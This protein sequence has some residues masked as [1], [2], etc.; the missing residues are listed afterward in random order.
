MI[1][2]APCTGPALAER[3]LPLPPRPA[4][5]GTHLLADLE[6]ASRLDEPA[7]V[8]ATLRA[9]ADAA[10][11]TLL[12][13]H[14]HQFTPTGGLTAVALLAESHVSIHTWPEYGFAAIDIFLCGNAPI[15]EALQ[16][17]QHAFKP[18]ETRSTVHTRGS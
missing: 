14:L 17:I 9:C 1:S 10:H 11:A 4:R 15:T 18:K 7:H 3:H 8:E 2:S 16:V 5:L 6:G 12:Q 13:F